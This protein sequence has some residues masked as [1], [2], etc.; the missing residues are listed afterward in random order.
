MAKRRVSSAK[1]NFEHNKRM[2]AHWETVDAKSR[3]TYINR[4]REVLVGNPSE[5]FVLRLAKGL[6]Y[7]DKKKQG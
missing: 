7:S 4:T 5:R 1:E 6:A 2:D 3:E